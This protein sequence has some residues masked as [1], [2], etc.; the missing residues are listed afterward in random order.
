MVLAWCPGRSVQVNRDFSVTCLLCQTRSCGAHFQQESYLLNRDTM[1]F[2]MGF[3]SQDRV[4]LTVGA[5]SSVHT[6]ASTSLPSAAASGSAAGGSRGHGPV[7]RRP[8][9]CIT[10]FLQLRPWAGISHTS[11]YQIKCSSGI[12][13]SLCL[14]PSCGNGRAP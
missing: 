2:R 8:P 14:S 5:I 10:Y 11:T 6:V 4:R 9:P 1:E 12:S 13:F 7:R 3:V